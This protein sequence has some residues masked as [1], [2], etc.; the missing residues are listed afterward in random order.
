MNL[1]ARKRN[2]AVP[3]TFVFFG[4]GSRAAAFSKTLKLKRG[5]EEDGLCKFPYRVAGYKRG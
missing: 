4:N 1:P 3:I 2:S 5:D